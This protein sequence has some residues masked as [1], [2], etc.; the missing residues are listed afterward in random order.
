MTRDSGGQ[1]ILFAAAGSSCPEAQATFDRI[2]RQA[3]VRFPG[4]GV[5][6]AF[7][8]SGVRRKLDQQGRHRADPSEAL[9]TMQAEGFTSVAVTSLHLSDGM[10]YGELSATVDSFRNG[11]G[12][13]TK[14]TLGPALMADENIWRR[15]VS[16]VLEAL[17]ARQ[18]H[19]AVILVAHGSL[20]PRAVATLAGAIAVCRQVDPALFLG[21]ILGSPSQKDILE[22]C[23]VAG[24][25]KV[26]LVPCL[27]A[28]GLSV[29]DVIMGSGEES[30]KSCFERAG[31]TC[32][33]VFKGLG[34]YDG[35][36]DVW[37]NQSRRLLEVL[38][39]P[40]SE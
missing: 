20:D 40:L 8:S 7:T 27:V 1:G 5:R 38:S 28:V 18:G 16:S 12:S 37:M 11:K 36:V 33:P 21:M 14:V 35:I 15:V 2:G 24:V 6:W 13:L 10:E 25:R 9:S 3:A 17:S 26:W 34:D 32:V 22:E 23:R 19:E 30:W 39:K 4:I 29:Q 31:I